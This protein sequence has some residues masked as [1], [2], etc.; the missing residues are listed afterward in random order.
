MARIEGKIKTFSF[1]VALMLWASATLSAPVSVGRRTI[2]QDQLQGDPSASVGS[3]VSPGTAPDRG[4][5]ATTRGAGQGSSNSRDTSSNLLPDQASAPSPGRGPS[6]APIQSASVVVPPKSISTVFIPFSARAFYESNICSSP[7]MEWVFR[8]LS[9]TLC[10]ISCLRD[11]AFE[12]MRLREIG[13]PL[14]CTTTKGL[15][16]GTGAAGGS[17]VGVGAG[18]GIGAGLPVGAGA[19]GLPVG[20]GGAGNSAGVGAAAGGAGAGTPAGAQNTGTPSGIVGGAAASTAGPGRSS[21]TSSGQATGPSGIPPGSLATRGSIAGIANA[22]PG[23]VGSDQGD[24]AD[25]LS[26]G[27]SSG[28]GAGAGNDGTAAGLSSSTGTRTRSGTGA[29]GIGAGGTGAG[30][31]GTPGVSNQLTPDQLASAGTF[32]GTGAG[33]ASSQGLATDSTDQ[34]GQQNQLGATGI[35]SQSAGGDGLDQMSLGP[36]SDP[37]RDSGNG[38]SSS[39]NDLSDGPG[40][41]TAGESSDVEYFSLDYEDYVDP[42]SNATRFAPYS[43]PPYLSWADDPA[44]AALILGQ[45]G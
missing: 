16:A 44:Y 14:G 31:V 33:Q 1:V 21:T 20:A 9:D 41:L 25:G 5:A 29:V 17:G 37:T 15:G 35:P 27:P 12:S 7:G 34:N 19:A 26:V 18:A 22:N 40:D 4:A 3:E 42:V 23:A 45:G 6:S 10:G 39:E 43:A 32:G 30:L 13:V 28:P 2:L 38:S 11:A 36:P 24:P 8:Q